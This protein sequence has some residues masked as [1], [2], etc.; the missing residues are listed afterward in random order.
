MTENKWKLI[1]DGET[2]KFFEEMNKISYKNPEKWI[3]IKSI[4]N[5]FVQH[6]DE[7]TEIYNMEN[8]K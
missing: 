5:K 7:A 4:F 3:E 1:Y 2:Y 6:M 8:K